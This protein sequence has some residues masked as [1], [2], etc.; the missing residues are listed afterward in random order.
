[1]FSKLGTCYA[2]QICMLLKSLGP[3]ITTCERFCIWYLRHIF[4][5][6]PHKNLQLLLF[7][8]RACR[9]TALYIVNNKHENHFH[10]NIGMPSCIYSY[11][12][13]CSLILSLFLKMWVHRTVNTRMS[14]AFKR[15]SLLFQYVWWHS[16]TKLMTSFLHTRAFVQLTH[17]K[18]LW[19]RHY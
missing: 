5:L 12:F 7:N 13:P 4:F 14:K 16:T 6:I 1:M 15:L 17:H 11:Y 10:F 8:G 3:T 2:I 19:E 9:S 18:Q